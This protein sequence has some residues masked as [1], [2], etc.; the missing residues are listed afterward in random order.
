MEEDSLFL[1]KIVFSDGATFHLLGKVNP[2]NLITRG[3]QNPHQVVEHVRDRRRIFFCALSRSTG[4]RTIIFRRDSHY[5]SGVRR[6]AG[7]LPCSTAGCKECDLATRWGSSP[8]SQG[9]E[10]V[11]EPNIPRMMDRSW[12]LYSV[13]TQLTHRFFIVL[14]YELDLVSILLCHVTTSN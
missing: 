4:L 5:G 7:T 3:S 8:L 1:D 12:R 9:R 11:A 2:C 6:H 14:I 13:L 10:A